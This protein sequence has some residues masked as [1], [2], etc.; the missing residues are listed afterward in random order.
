MNNF[1]R[2]TKKRNNSLIKLRKEDMKLNVSKSKQNNPESFAGLYE[3]YLKNRKMKMAEGTISRKSIEILSSNNL[4]IFIVK[5]DV[6]IGNN[7]KFTLMNL[8]T[9]IMKNMK[10]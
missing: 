1:L 7:P 10:K 3:E 5:N 9:I 8:M 2:R 4:N 6:L